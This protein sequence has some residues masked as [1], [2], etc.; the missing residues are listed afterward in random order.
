[1]NSGPL[2]VEGVVEIQHVGGDPVRQRRI[3]GR[4]ALRSAHDAAV[5]DPS[6]GSRAWIP[7]GPGRTGWRSPRWCNRASQ[8]GSG[9]PGVPRLRVLD[10]TPHAANVARAPLIEKPPVTTRSSLLDGKEFCY[11]D[12]MAANAHSYDDR[13][14][15]ET[16]LA[17]LRAPHRRRGHTRR[18]AAREHPV[19]ARSSRPR[20]RRAEEP[21]ARIVREQCRLLGGEPQAR[22]LGTHDRLRVTDAVRN[23][24]ACH[25]LDFD[26]THVPTIL[27]PTTP[28]YAAGTA[29]AEWRGSRGSICWPRTPSGTSWP[30]A[31]ATRCTPSTTTWA[32]T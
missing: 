19:P 3:T 26:D 14:S 16:H 32:G 10:R 31:Q 27:H 6:P 1:M 17:R 18:R 23:G 13:T 30:L 7:P 28:L 4:G 12:Y 11:T 2:G 25:A 29:L 8:Q 21:A 5:R 22:V 20:H 9:P 15:F 24:I